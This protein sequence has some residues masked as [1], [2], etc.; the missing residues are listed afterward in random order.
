MKIKNK[1]ILFTIIFSFL[2]T[3]SIFAISGACSSHGGVNCSMGRQLNGKVVCNDGWTDSI[4][5]Y[6]FMS[7][8][9]DYK[10]SCNQAEWDNLSKKYEIEDLLSKMREIINEMDKLIYSKS[11]QKTELDILIKRYNLY[12][13]QYEIA[14][15]LAEGQCYAIGSDRAYK[16]NFERMQLEFYNNQ[17]EESQKK[18]EES[19]KRI[20][21]IKEE[22]NKF[23]EWYRVEME[24]L[25]KLAQQT[26][27]SVNSIP[28][29]DKCQCISGY[30]LNTAKNGCIKIVS[31][32]SNAI[33]IQGQCYCERD[34][35]WNSSKTACIKIEEKIQIDKK[36]EP[37]LIEP[38][39]EVM[40][41]EKPKLEIQE[42]IQEEN[43]IEPEVLKEI[44][45]ENQEE[46]ETKE[47]K[48][49]FKSVSGFFSNTYNSVKRFFSKIF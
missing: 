7:I 19:Q 22:E 21:E 5:D 29:G 14:L 48:G 39:K 15:M 30:E 43:K 36:I 37:L 23:E 17:L 4:A 44:K 32:P 26:K 13:S 20:E 24:K 31:C 11:P 47:N 49:F 42:F 46:Q 35:N 3:E 28:V 25:N 8:C 34:Y 18:I 12:E 40:I 33:N 6:D 38:K 27:C 16:N 2:F 9:K 10:F 1:L 45:N 41:E